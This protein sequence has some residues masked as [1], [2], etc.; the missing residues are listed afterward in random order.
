M[1]ALVII[2]LAVVFIFILPRKVYQLL[3]TRKAAQTATSE[4]SINEKDLE[5]QATIKELYWIVSG[6][7]IG[8]TAISVAWFV[9]GA[10]TADVAGVLF[11]I[12]SLF[13]EPVVIGSREAYTIGSLLIVVLFVWYLIQSYV[14]IEPDE[15]ATLLIFGWPAFNLHAQ[16]WLVFKPFCKLVYGPNTRRQAE[17]PADSSR[18]WHGKTEDLLK[19]RENEPEYGWVE[20]YRVTT[21]GKDELKEGDSPLDAR[22]TV[23]VAFVLAWK[24][25][26]LRRAIRVLG[27]TAELDKETGEP[28]GREY[29]NIEEGFRQLQDTTR[30]SLNA[31]FGQKTPR[32]I[33]GDQNK[34]NEELIEKLDG[35]V[36]TNETW[37]GIDVLEVALTMIGF[38]HDFNKAMKD[39]PQARF[40]AA[41]IRTIAKATGFEKAQEIEQQLRAF[42]KALDKSENPAFTLA[43][44]QARLAEQGLKAVT[45]GDGKLVLIGGGT[46]GVMQNAFGLVEGLDLSKLT[47]G[48]SQQGG[49]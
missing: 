32:E 4:D 45:D 27:T 11:T 17:Y 3:K 26:N 48:N 15:Q 31:M 29:L 1:K 19:L 2:F 34:I 12:P 37:W 43:F 20:A 28:T 9:Y 46:G 23:E 5:E 40:E 25:A 16:P 41:K 47:A 49:N 8:L 18:I 7:L 36:L 24:V 14:E 10:W 38:S 13:F 42:Q 6:A 22:Q 44:I 33:L 30:R 35:V 39:A 21:G